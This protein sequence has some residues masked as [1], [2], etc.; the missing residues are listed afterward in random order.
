MSADAAPAATPSSPW[1][2][3]NPFPGRLVVN[4][5]LSGD[6]SDKDTRHFEIDLANWGLS[7]EPGDSM[8]VWATNDRQLVEDMIRALGATGAELVPSTKKGA[9]PIPLRQALSTEYSITQPT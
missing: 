3:S 1:S 2:R 7:Y 9:A 8:A 4:R 5:R 6:D